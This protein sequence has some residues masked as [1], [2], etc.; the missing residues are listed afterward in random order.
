MS[1]YFSFRVISF[2]AICCLLS[3]KTAIAEEF[4]D[5][6]AALF[7]AS[8]FPGKE[9]DKLLASVRYKHAIKIFRLSQNPQLSALAVKQHENL[10]LDYAMSSIFT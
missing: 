4:A 9:G 10:A 8:S 1:M 7:F 6:K 5:E 3:P 2:V